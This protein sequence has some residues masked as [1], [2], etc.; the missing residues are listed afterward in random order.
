MIRY[1]TK[2]PVTNITNGSSIPTVKCTSGYHREPKFGSIR[3]LLTIT[4][5]GWSGVTKGVFGTHSEYAL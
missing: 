4:Y 1:L 2:A 3:V 5:T